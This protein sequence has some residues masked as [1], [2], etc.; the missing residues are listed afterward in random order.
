MSIILIFFLF[1]FLIRKCYHIS[2]ERSDFMA[3]CPYLDW[4][5]HLFS[6]DSKVCKL[7]NEYIPSSFFSNYCQ[8]YNYCGNCPNYKQYGPSNGGCFITTITCDILKKEDNCEEMNNLRTLRNNYLQLNE[9]CYEILKLYDVIGPIIADRLSIDPNKKTVANTLFKYIIKPC[10]SLIEKG[11][12][13]LATY[14][15][16]LMTL[17]LIR[18]YDLEEEY[19]NLK[20]NDYGYEDFNPSTAGFGKKSTLK[21]NINFE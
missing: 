19:R 21:K 12:Y 16:Y 14:R 10:S 1:D 18:Y 3:Y 4:Q 6:A 20:N 7:T 2:S 13:I 5:Q 15:Y 9:E 8:N 17:E 11:D